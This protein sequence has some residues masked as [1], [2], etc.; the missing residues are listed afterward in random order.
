[1]DT[2]QKQMPSRTHQTHTTQKKWRQRFPAVSSYLS[3]DLENL[4]Q[5]RFISQ[6]PWRR[7]RLLLLLA[8]KGTTFEEAADKSKTLLNS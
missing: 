5:P 1:V 2:F 3:I 7:Q 4:L 6:S 8:T